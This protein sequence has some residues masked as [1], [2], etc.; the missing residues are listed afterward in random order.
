MRATV[1]VL[2]AG[3]G[4]GRALVRFFLLQSISVAF[5]THSQESMDSLKHEC[6][7]FK[8]LVSSTASFD[9]CD[10]TLSEAFVRRLAS[11]DNRND[12][13]DLAIYSAGY[14]FG[15]QCL[16]EA[17]DIESDRE[18]DVNFRAPLFWSKRLSRHFVERGRGGHL[19]ISSGVASN[20]RPSWGAYG[21]AKAGVEALSSQ[22]S[23][24]LPDPLFSVSLNPGGMST[25][26]RQIAYPE[27]NRQTLPSPEETGSRIGRFCLELMKGRGR[28]HNGNR[29][30]V[31]DVG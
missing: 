29:L 24:D 3:S 4:L 27:E 22:L 10:R 2:G 28:A 1:L 14:L 11:G 7:S 18:I 31:G 21:I 19:F 20:P 23:L 8:S 5:V 12:F 30:D 16:F 13:P 17:P 15:R 9:Y 6:A 26:I 25:K